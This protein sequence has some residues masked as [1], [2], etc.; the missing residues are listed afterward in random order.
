MTTSFETKSALLETLMRRFRDIM[1]LNS[2]MPKVN[3]LVSDE[4]VKG[5]EKVE[6]Q[7]KPSI[8]F[9]PSKKELDLLQEY[10]QQNLQK[11]ADTVGDNLRQEIQRSLL[12]NDDVD[13]L[14]RKVKQLF[15]DK[16][17]ISR[18]KTVI[19]T[20]G[21][22][23]GNQGTLEGA[24]QAESNGVPV[25]KWLDVTRDDVTSD[26]CKHE[27]SKYGSPDKAINLDDD[28]KVKVKNKTYIAK[29]PPFHPN[30]RSVLRIVRV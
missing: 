29:N 3:E 18:L 9:V 14:T 19:R 1:S 20:E 8:N 2:F 12:N 17:Y 11:H 23:A 28:F 21:L 30:C 15:R 25:K 4:Y 6:N 24:K 22:R 16:K 27:D 10:V 5:L 13:M 7:L 26:I